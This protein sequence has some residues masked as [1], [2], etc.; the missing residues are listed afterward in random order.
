MRELLWNENCY[1]QNN[2]ILG[3][4]DPFGQKIYSLKSCWNT[5]VNCPKK[6]NIFYRHYAGTFFLQLITQGNFGWFSKLKNDQNIAI[7]EKVVFQKLATPHA[8]GRNKRTGCKVKLFN[9]LPIQMRETKTPNTFKTK[10]TDWIWK[11][12]PSY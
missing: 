12:I 9:M 1:L 5:G 8:K 11:N 3:T 10:T 7:F 4:S 6:K 2:K